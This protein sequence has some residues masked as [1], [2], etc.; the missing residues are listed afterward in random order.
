MMRAADLTP[1]LPDGAA[2][3]CDLAGID[4]ALVMKRLEAG[5]MAKK[6]LESRAIRASLI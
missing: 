2:S 5:E 6:Q 3:A 4:R 1:A